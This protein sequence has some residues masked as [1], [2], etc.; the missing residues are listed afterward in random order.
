[1]INLDGKYTLTIVGNTATIKDTGEVV[2]KINLS[3][4]SAKI[5]DAYLLDRTAISETI[6][7]L[8][9]YLE[10]EGVKLPR[11]HAELCG[12]VYLHKILYKLNYR[13]SQTKDCDLDYVA[14]RRW[15]VNL[16]SKLLGWILF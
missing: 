8:I 4:S 16:A 9:I 15:Y 14:D 6:T 11:T 5:I 7:F 3:P 12:E 2:T 10:D 1:M 13:R